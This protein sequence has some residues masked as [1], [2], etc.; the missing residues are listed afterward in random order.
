MNAKTR[1]QLPA[2]VDA[3]L[4][5][6]VEDLASE[7]GLALEE[8]VDEALADLLA[9]HRHGTPD[10]MAAYNKS[11]EKFAELYKKLAK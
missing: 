7:E 11:H 1:I 10:V 9:K 5:T 6:A 8:L 3:K 4:V 2:D